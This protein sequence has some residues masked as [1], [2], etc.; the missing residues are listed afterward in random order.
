M[1]SVI[2]FLGCSQNNKNNLNEKASVFTVDELPENPLSL[3][4]ITFSINPTKATMST[5]YGN[6]IA[7]HHAMNKANNHYPNGAVLY[8]VTWHQKADSLWF[9][10]NIPDKIT[11]I[12]RI[13]F[14]EDLLPKYELYAG[15][16]LKKVVTKDESKRIAFIISQRMANNP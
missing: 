14:S 12:E 16:P 10:A 1:A 6:S 15:S 3:S 11:L 8:E 2:L 13:K 7:F 9:G 4:P 5:L